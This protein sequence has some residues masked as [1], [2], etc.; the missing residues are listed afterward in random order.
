MSRGRIQESF[1]AIKQEGRTGL[2]VFL[3]AGFPDRK[4]TL[5]LVPKLVAAGADLVELGVPFSDPLA[6]GPTIQESSFRALQDRV[7]LRDCLRMVEELRGLV[8]D[9]PLILMGYYNPVY[10]YGLAPFA[11]DAQRAGV[12]GLIVVDLPQFETGPLAAQC[13]PRDIPIIPLLA[14]TSTDESI[15][16]S[17]AGAAAGFIYCISVTG[18]T[19]AREQVSDRS[20]RLV[21]RVRPHTSLPLAVGFGISRREHVEAVGRKAEAAVVGSA[22]VRVML[23]SPRDQLAERAGR[24][25]GELAG[26]PQPA[27]GGA[28]R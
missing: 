25:V 9:T 5:E 22:L 15:R 10:R 8:P 21:D 17:C 28:E 4:A 27:R 24:L 23:E 13:A 2:V 18:V 26:K 16:A 14:P 6:E 20:F 11:Q 12:D 19:G 1:A 7:S 3:T